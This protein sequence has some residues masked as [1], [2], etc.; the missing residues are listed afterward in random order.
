M[1]KELARP[2]Y[3]QNSLDFP[4][5]A[6]FLIV[7]GLLLAN[8]VLHDPRFCYDVTHHFNYIKTL[9]TLEFPSYR[10]SHE[11]FSPPLPY[12]IPALA[13]ALGLDIFW[14][15]KAAQLS[16]LFAS[17]LALYF[18]LKISRLVDASNLVAR[19]A[20]LMLGILP[21]YYKT[22][23]FIRGEPWV[24]AFGVTA[25][26]FYLRMVARGEFS[27][28]NAALAGVSLGLAGLSRQWAISYFIAFAC[29]TAVYIFIKPEK[30]RLAGIYIL[31]ALVLGA[32]ICSPFYLSLK[33]R[34]G[35]F[36]AF[37]REP[38]E[39]FSLSNQP[40]SFYL[41]LSPD[42]LFKNPVR[43][44]FPNQ[45]VPVFYSELWGDYWG[46]F[47][48][49]CK[50]NRTG[51][52]KPASRCA[53]II[54][55]R[56]KPEWME[57]NYDT[58]GGYLG[59]VNLVSLFPTFLALLAI[60]LAL[61]YAVSGRGVDEESFTRRTGSILFLLSLAASLSIYLWFLVMFPQPGEGDTI[62]ASYLLH[63]FLHMAL[64]S[65]MLLK[66]AGERSRLL[67]RILAA[68]LVLVWAHNLPAMATN[69]TLLKYLF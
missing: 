20:L 59:R 16:N 63:E 67:L 34:T 8:L 11:F 61:K 58:V 15:G 64:L 31:S 18:L 27:M 33:L 32:L 7:N 30:A 9:S 19:G 10:Q 36:S 65:G 44:A 42:K 51:A 56:G 1:L 49:Y 62:K 12:V 14:A 38:A 13:Y 47:T 52:Y 22:F 37:N 35:R 4:L 46:F 2:F 68:L 69:Y 29:C 3:R 40:R 23:A 48:V 54:S 53:S 55:D 25:A 28:R 26:Y 39:S 45:L 50:D 21:V 5:L 24:A 43:P 17:L 41:G 6:L 60:A 57:T 66:A